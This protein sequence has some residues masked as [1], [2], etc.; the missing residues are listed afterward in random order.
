ML[1]FLRCKH[2]FDTASLLTSRRL[3]AV[4]VRY[5]RRSVEQRLL[6]FSMQSVSPSDMA[7]VK[8]FRK[9]AAKTMNKKKVLAHSEFHQS[10]S[11]LVL[12]QTRNTRL[13]GQSSGALE[14][15][16]I[17]PHSIG[18]WSCQKHILVLRN[19]PISIHNWAP[20]NCVFPSVLDI[21]SGRTRKTLC[22]FSFVVETVLSQVLFFFYL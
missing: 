10:E 5:C 1:I 19:Q 3:T 8:S 13:I 12:Q 9:M 22:C 16:T 2:S 11:R 21:F 18:C 17:L 14:F 6:W 15:V 4:L 7:P 20:I